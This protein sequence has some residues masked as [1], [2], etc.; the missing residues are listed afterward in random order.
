MRFVSGP[1]NYEGARRADVHHVECTEFVGE[2][3]RPKPTVAANIDA[4][5]QDDECHDP[6]W[7]AGGPT[8]RATAITLRTGECS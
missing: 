4:A 3:L 6:P 5:Q 7:N 2:Q 8:S 1:P